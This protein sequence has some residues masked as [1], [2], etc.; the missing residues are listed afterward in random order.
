MP[1]HFRRAKLSLGELRFN[2]QQSNPFLNNSYC[3]S[4]CFHFLMKITEVIVTRIELV[5]YTRKKEK[6]RQVWVLQKMEQSNS[7]ISPQ[8]S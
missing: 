8:L 4:L 7:S 3:P 5:N 2:I 6:K 1:F